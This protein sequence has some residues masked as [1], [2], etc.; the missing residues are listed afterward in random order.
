MIEVLTLSPDRKIAHGSLMQMY[1]MSKAWKEILMLRP[2]NSL[3]F[4]SLLL[5][6]SLSF[7]DSGSLGSYR[8][9]L[10]Q[11]GQS[12][13]FKTLDESQSQILAGV[14]KRQGNSFI[15]PKSC[16]LNSKGYAG[17]LAN[18]EN[19]RSIFK[20]PSCLD[21]NTDLKNT[22][23]NVVST[24][25]D[26]QN[27]IS[28][29]TGTDSTGDVASHING[30]AINSMFNNIN[31][32]FFQNSCKLNNAN[33]LERSADIIQ[34]FSQMGLLV[35]NSNGL[36]IA[37]GGLALSSIL[38]L[39]NK[40]FTKKFDFEDNSERASFIKLNCAFY[41]IRREIEQSGLTDIA[42]P[43]YSKDLKAINELLVTIDKNKK[44]NQRF[45]NE[46]VKYFAKEKIDYIVKEEGKL[47]GLETNIDKAL[48]IV[49]VK[50]TDRENG[51]IPAETV[52]K[53][54]LINLV[55]IHNALETNLRYYIDHKLS[56]MAI[57]DLDLMNELTKLDLSSHSDDFMTLFQMEPGKFNSSFRAS[58]LFHFERVQKDIKSLKKRFAAKWDTTKL[59][60]GKTV[61]E[62]E[63]G[64]KQKLSSLSK[65]QSNTAAKLLPIKTRLSRIV[66]ADK[67]FTRT[68]DGTE[69]KTAILSSY[70]EIANQ[71]YGKW[72]YEFLKYTTKTAKKD[73]DIFKEKFSE[74]AY[75]HLI[76]SG[77][78]VTTIED[79]KDISDLK[80]LYACQ[81]AKPLARRWSQAN[82]LVQ[83]GYDF[84]VTNK[85][86][87]HSDHPE[88]FLSG[89][90]QV[91][92]V[93][94]K[95]QDH[96]KSSLFAQRLL[97]GEK[98]SKKNKEK[99][100]GKKAK[101]RKYLGTVMLSVEESKARAQQLQ[102][103]D[104]E[105][106]C[107]KLTTLDD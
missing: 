68:D 26:I 82:S 35:P 73:N 36:V 27:V 10:T 103:L 84:V 75:A 76:V 31:G 59:V 97:K 29:Q 25:S 39:L 51:T 104:N 42:L 90:T 43:E 11:A 12:L 8:N 2:L 32:L 3:V 94:V 92:T 19:V 107:S 63:K 61:A 74:F 80:I 5:T 85:E 64:L 50:V 22:Y 18:I 67:G 106:D 41:D 65:V 17:I 49:S 34:N 77:S 93:F 91:R 13:Q 33:M 66:G 7:A 62:Y 14:I 6:S 48:K 28:S 58:L 1:K 44:M 72:G 81:D 99:Y 45:F 24:G 23:D 69:N 102:K 83:Q 30:T 60:D 46:Q 101:R 70:D 52:K 98:V 55:N 56:S 86:L 54:M 53:E 47:K 38:K 9:I 78:G 89:I 96:H 21:K 37:G 100:L 79:K 15:R 71:I 4:S 88:A 20:D 16:P 105:Y 57:L 95:I 40:L 87:F